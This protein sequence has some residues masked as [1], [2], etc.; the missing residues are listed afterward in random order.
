MGLWIPD[1]PMIVERLVPARGESEGVQWRVRIELA[2]DPLVS[3]P[4][5]SPA[6]ALRSIADLLDAC[7]L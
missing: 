2:V 1:V 7:G 6:A 5:A 4:A 3:E